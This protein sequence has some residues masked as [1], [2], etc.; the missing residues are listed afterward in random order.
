MGDYNE[1]AK[2]HWQNFQ[3][4]ISAEPRDQFLSK[5]GAMYLCMKGSQVFMNGQWFN[6]QKKD[7][8]D[9]FCL[10]VMAS[11]S[12]CANVFNDWTVSRVSDVAH[13]PLVFSLK[14]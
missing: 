14:I 10:D 6:Y 9:F 11:S 2:I 12:H 4:V 3:K 7:D 13:G 5:L 1:I 8:F